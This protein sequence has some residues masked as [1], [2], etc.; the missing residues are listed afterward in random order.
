MLNL[1][2]TLSAFYLTISPFCVQISFMHGPKMVRKLAAG[3]ITGN[4]IDTNY[5]QLGCSIQYSK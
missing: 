4:I 1:H 3:I 5:W 2:S